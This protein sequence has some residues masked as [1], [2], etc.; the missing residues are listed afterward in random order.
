MRDAKRD[1]NVTARHTRITEK[2]QPLK[3]KDL[4]PLLLSL[5]VV[6]AREP[7]RGEEE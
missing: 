3:S 6:T 5:C 4:N 1:V 2:P 7:G